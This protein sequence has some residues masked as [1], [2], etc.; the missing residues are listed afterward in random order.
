MHDARTMHAPRCFRLN[1]GSAREIPL[2]YRRQSRLETPRGRASTGIF[3][4]RISRWKY[5]ISGP[6]GLWYL[7]I[8][9]DDGDNNNFYS[10]VVG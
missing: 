10:G 2:I 9:N 7:Y 3:L 5:I 1:R 8:N 6:D 4:H